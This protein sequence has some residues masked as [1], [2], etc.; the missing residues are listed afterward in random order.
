MFTF[1]RIGYSDVAWKKLDGFS[2][3]IICQ[4]KE[5]LDFVAETQN[6]EP[7]VAT[8]SSG[9]QLVG[10]FTGL[11]VR[12]MGMRILGSP[13][14][15]WSTI[16]MGF[17]L[18]PDVNRTDVLQG[19]LQFAFRRLNCIQVE[20]MDRGLTLEDA[21]GLGF[22]HRM[23]ENFE[24][25]LTQSEDEL[26]KRLKPKSARYSINKAKKLGVTITEGN[27]EGFAE[28]YYNQLVDVFA[29]QSLK[30]TYDLRRVEALIDNLYPGGNL[31]LLRAHN[32]ARECLATG[33][34]PGNSTMAYFWG[35]ASW[36]ETQLYCPNEP[37]VW[38]AIKYWQARGT[39]AFDFGGAGEYKRKYGGHRISVPWF[40]KS[41]YPGLETLR[42]IASKVVS[43]RQRK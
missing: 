27:P 20:I 12:K 35:A 30:P 37:L 8:I 11:I 40:R 9:S 39:K 16:Y 42:A 29:K 19:L 31:L 1:E 24:I 38:H 3:R 6:A 14:P 25:D 26:W 17:N 22:A 15:G 10:Y 34:F 4:S 32:P 41:K 33:I 43:L 36:R 23:L 5:W 21:Q 2:G 18:E 28:E 13:F 7:V